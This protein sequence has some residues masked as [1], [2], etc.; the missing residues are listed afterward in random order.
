MSASLGPSEATLSGQ[1]LSDSVY[2]WRERMPYSIV[3]IIETECYEVMNLLGYKVVED[4]DELR[5]TN[6]PL[7]D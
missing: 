7:V 1:S 3:R 4:M 5:A 6:I 2:K